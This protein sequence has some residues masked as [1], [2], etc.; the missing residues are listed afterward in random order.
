MTLAVKVRHL[1][2]KQ[3]IK[4]LT[5]TKVKALIADYKFN[6]AVKGELSIFDRIE[7]FMEK[8]ENAGYQHFLFFFP[9]NF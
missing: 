5:F 1:T 8:R 6:V 4:I 2:T 3:S 9:T 7:N